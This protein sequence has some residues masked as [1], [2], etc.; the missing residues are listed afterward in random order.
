MS[1]E[2]RSS[3]ESFPIEV[4]PDLYRSLSPEAREALRRETIA[5]L[6]ALGHGQ[7]S[8]LVAQRPGNGDAWRTV[9]AVSDA[10]VARLLGV[11]LSLRAMERSGS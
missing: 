9:H 11:L 7:L 4:R 10:E 5:S 8:A 2:T 1:G 6:D 3:G